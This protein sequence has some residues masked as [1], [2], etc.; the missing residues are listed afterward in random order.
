MRGAI[1]LAVFALT[2]ATSAAERADHKIL[3]GRD[4]KW[5]LPPPIVEMAAPPK[6]AMLQVQYL[7]RQVRISKTGQETYTAQ[8]FTILRP[9]ALP[10]ANLQFAW[11]PSNGSVTVHS[12]RLHR[13]D[14]SVTDMLGKAEF[15]IIQREEGLEQ[16]ALT[17]LKTAIFAIPGVEVGDAISFAATIS[18]RDPTLGPNMFGMLQMPSIEIGGLFRTRLLK[19]DDLALDWRI[20]RDLTGFRSEGADELRVELLNPK[21]ANLPQGAPGRFL[22]GRLIEWSSF[23]DWPQISS[24]FSNLFE[25][26]STLDKSSPLNQEIEKISAANSDPEARARA[27]LTLVQDRVRY[28]Y[29]GLGTGNYT[30]AS[31][32]LTWE[33]R[34]GDC[35]GKSALLLALLKGLGISAEAVLVNQAGL[36]GAEDHLP[37]PGMFDHVVVRATINGRAYWLDGTQLRSPKLDLLPA[38]NYRTALPLRRAGGA[39]ESVKLE[40]LQLPML[41]ELV[42]IDASGGIG[43]PAHIKTRQILN[44]ADVSQYRAGL[45]ALAGD[46]LNR[47]IRNLAQYSD[48]P[49]EG[50]VTS[51][52]YDENTAALTMQWSATQQLDWEEDEDKMPWLFISGAG[53]NSPDRFE[54]PKEQD[55]T[56]P[57]AVDQPFFKCW[58]TTIR[59]PKD[60][61]RQRWTYSSKPVN[62]VIGGYEYYRQATLKNGVIQTI[63]SR[64]AITSELSA[65]EAKKA[66]EQMSDF[67]NEKSYI[68][69]ATVGPD[70]GNTDDPREVTDT[71][72]LDWLSGGPLCRAPTAK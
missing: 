16:A 24:L 22:A 4:P 19:G 35:K 63:M 31:A 60:S 23:S 49:G 52:S 3:Q 54:R 28:V 71:S 7:D 39:L 18:D 1:I 26:A 34:F 33:R 32:D 20:S 70:A 44:G 42:D 40:P 45:S 62:R 8:R 57:W 64:R 55:Q 6:D 61:V 9:D 66:N 21:S 68:Y 72:K 14:G 11:K 67:N 29:V 41:L 2:S 43:K 51:W 53:F 69:L 36:D 58:I 50:E 37:S 48:K 25:A 10:A 15:Q 13:K 65:D 27:A 59:L 30:P 38:P 47:A 17:G 5:A 46:D 12:I 56:A